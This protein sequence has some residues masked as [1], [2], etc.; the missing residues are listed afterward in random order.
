MDN[1]KTA[2]VQGAGPWGVLNESYRRYASTVRFHIDPCL[3]HEPAHKGKVERAVLTQR[4]G[5][6]PRRHTWDSIEALQAWSDQHVDRQARKRRCPATGSSVWEAW[7]A[8]RP[9]LAPLPILPVPFDAIATRRVSHDGLVS[10]EGRQYSVPFAYLGQQ[11]EIRG[12]V[13]RIQIL[14]GTTTVAEH[15]RGTAERLVLNPDHYE[16]PST[17][18]VR[19]PMPLGRLGRRLQELASIPV[20]HRPIDLYA[21]LAAVAR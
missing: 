15:P 19:A 1:T 8:E 14:A 11:V 18:T 13:A 12:G 6:D 17:P 2:V 10:F 7:Q 21:A 9:F 16:G 4:L 20:E 3:P 5:A